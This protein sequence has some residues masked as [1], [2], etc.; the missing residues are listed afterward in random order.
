M[1]SHSGPII[2]AG[3]FNTWNQKRLHLVKEITQDIQ[4]KE[5]TDFPEGRKTGD[6]SSTFWNKVLGIEKDLPLDR[7]F[8]NGFK[9]ST[10]RVLNFTSSDHIPILI[11]LELYH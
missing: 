6:T 4:L 10:A 9:P 5:V 2:M 3:D 7:F 8:F 11:T 1:A